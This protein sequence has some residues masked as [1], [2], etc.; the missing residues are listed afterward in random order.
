[1]TQFGA[2]Y[3]LIDT[4]H[5][6][7]ADRLLLVRVLVRNTGAATW[8]NRG[9]HP[10]NLGYHWLAPDG[11]M[12]EFEGLRVGLPAPLPPGGSAEVELQVEPPAPGNYLL[13]VDLVE[14]EVDWFSHQGVAWLTMPLVVVAAPTGALHVC[15]IAQICLIHDAVSNHVLDQARALLAKGYQVHMV[16]EVVDPRQPPELRQLMAPISFE[17]LRDAR[18]RPQSRRA[19]NSFRSADL[20]IFHFPVQYQLFEAIRFV[21]RGIVIVDYHGITPPHL[22]AATGREYERLIASQQQLGLV[23][24][25][26][27]AIA[28]SAYTRDELLR[29]GAILPERVYQIH[30]PVD[31]DRFQPQAPPDDLAVR[32]GLA[33]GQPVLLYVGRMAANKRIDDLL[34]ALALIRRRYPSTVLLLVG[35]NRSDTYAQIAEHVRA[36][37]VELEVSDKVIFTGQVPDAELVALYQMADL[38]VTASLHEGFCIPVIEAMASGL[39]VVGTNT[40][41]LP[42]TIGDA[43]LTFQPKNPSDL[44][45]VI[46]EILDS[47]ANGR[48]APVAMQDEQIQK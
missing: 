39:P 9:P 12:V 22:W 27:Y 6:A 25:A 32:Y 37:A 2:E 34:Q 28:H 33:A 38:F 45:R 17:D 36:L 1:M 13:A 11:R 5:E 40:T 20:Y 16:L 31:V 30:L 21:E 15:I 18:E 19:L 42:E 7:R 47:Q 24:Y 41:A 29:T 26:D 35:D 43:G 23:R 8:A 14:E 48:P 10:I 44:A 3:Q 4:P 46:I